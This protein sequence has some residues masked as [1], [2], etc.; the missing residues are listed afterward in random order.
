MLC[1]LGAKNVLMII[2]CIL[3]SNEKWILNCLP[4]VETIITYC[5]EIKLY[6][7]LLNISYSFKHDGRKCSAQSSDDHVNVMHFK[8]LGS[9]FYCIASM[10]LRSRKVVESILNK[11]IGLSN[12]VRFA[13]SMNGDNFRKKWIHHYRKCCP[14]SPNALIHSAGWKHSK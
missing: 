5:A 11:S 9:M 1:C 6:T 2:H 7:Y 10:N 3:T 12:W 13:Q 4:I 14:T 8:Q